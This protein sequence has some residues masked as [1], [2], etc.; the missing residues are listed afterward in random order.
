MSIELIDTEERVC[1]CGCENSFPVYSGWIRDDDGGEWGFSV[2]HLRHG[3][4]GG[5]HSFLLLGT[6][7][8]FKNDPRNCWVTFHTWLDNETIVTRLEDWEKTPFQPQ[9][10][11]GGR[12]LLREEVLSIPEQFEGVFEIYDLFKDQHLPTA[13]FLLRDY[14]E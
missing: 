7:P 1:N 2:A 5:P 6:G 14:Q 12:L 13:E 10:T 4:S 3:E 11:V 9:D 8:W